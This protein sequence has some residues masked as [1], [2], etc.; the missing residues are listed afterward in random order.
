MNENIVITLLKGKGNKTPL[1][2]HLMETQKIK[3]YLF[4]RCQLRMH[5]LHLETSA[6]AN[7]IDCCCHRKQKY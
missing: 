7:T 6:K 2:T 4:H 5:S 1:Q 3:T